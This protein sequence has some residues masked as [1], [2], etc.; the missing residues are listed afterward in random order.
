[1]Y[2]R[3]MLILGDEKN[4]ILIDNITKVITSI[5]ITITI[6]LSYSQFKIQTEFELK[7]PLMDLRVKMY[8]DILI[9]SAK[10]L[11]AAKNPLDIEKLKNSN[12]KL[13]N[14]Y[15][16]SFVVFGDPR[17]NEVYTKLIDTVDEIVE[18]NESRERSMSTDDF[19]N[20]YSLEIYSSRS[21]LA[22]CIG[23]TL[24]EVLNVQLDE[25]FQ[26]ISELKN[27]SIYCSI[28]DSDEYRILPNY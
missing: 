13:K 11:P 26:T 20:K 9:E 12:I 18:R 5:I 6:I 2:R 10:L 24:K 15:Y 27:H 7:K 25:K 3:I 28:P 1:M 4:S 19:Q 16:E 14:I 8:S 22:K 21:F 17:V 23:S